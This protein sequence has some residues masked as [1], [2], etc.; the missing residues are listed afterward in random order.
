ME[1][2]IVIGSSAAGKAGLI[3]EIAEDV[4]KNTKCVVCDDEQDLREIREL[5][6]SIHEDA[7]NFIEPEVKPF[8]LHDKMKYGKRDKKGKGKKDWDL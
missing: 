7:I 5:L 6:T 8:I 2:I 3:K 1:K 4:F